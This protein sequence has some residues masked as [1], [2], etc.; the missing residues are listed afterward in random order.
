MS[1]RSQWSFREA[2]NQIALIYKHSDGYPEG[3][4]GGFAVWNRFLAKVKEDCGKNNWSY[5]FNDAE[6]LAARFVYYLLR[7]EGGNE[8]L[9]TLGVGVSKELHGDI[10]YLYEID[11]DSNEVPQFRCKRVNSGEYVD[12]EGNPI[13][14][15]PKGTVTIKGRDFAVSPALSKEYKS[16]FANDSHKKLRRDANG[17]FIKMVDIAEFDYPHGYD[18]SNSFRLVKVI[19]KTKDYILGVQTNG[20]NT[21]L[22]RFNRNRMV[23]CLYYKGYLD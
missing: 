20:D 21:G 14:T 9:N 7:W 16:S 6:Y 3:Y 23:N 11:C 12:N 19:E 15:K 18:G 22:K 13:A 8:N 10:D 2:G 17:K 4:H 1:T 5:R